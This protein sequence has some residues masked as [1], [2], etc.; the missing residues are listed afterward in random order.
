[1]AVGLVSRRLAE[2]SVYFELILIFLGGIL[3]GGTL[4]APLVNYY[5]HGTFLTLNHAHTALRPPRHRGDLF[6][7][8]LCRRR[9]ASVW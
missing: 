7:P 6:L 4:H 8:A 1:M 5:E 9:P 3:G 2:G